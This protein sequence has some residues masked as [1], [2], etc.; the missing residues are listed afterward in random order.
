MKLNDK[1]FVAG[2]RGMVGS[3]IVRRLQQ[4]GYE[5]IVV[6]NHDKL[7]LTNQLWVN[8]FFKDEKP[9]YVFLAAARVGGI[10]ANDTYRAEFI[11]DN[12]MIEANVIH[13]AY[14]HGVK[15]LLA[16]GSSCIYP[17][18]SKR[19]LIE[20]DL[21]T[22]PLEPTNEPYAIAKVAGIKLC[23]AYRDQYGC[24]FISAMPCNIY[25]QG[26]NYGTNNTHV[27]PS[28]L[29]RFHEAKENNIP[30]VKVWGTGEPWREFVYS[31]D[32]ADACV[33][34]MNRYNGRLFLNIGTGVDIKIRDLAEKIKDVVGYGGHIEFDANMPDG[35]YRKVLNIEKLNSIGWKHTVSLDE[36]LQ[37]AYKYFKQELNGNNR[38]SN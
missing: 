9:D 36:G 21:M 12:L 23:E 15:K 37:M 26:D 6:R 31:D 4:D 22:G 1:I 28:L 24:N 20:E 38:E 25:G 11:Y 32:V 2:H 33:F 8:H 5:N 35:T 30:Y 34:M 7:D 16:L 14:V 13:A 17:R 3:A 29:R 27:L 18:E 19:P 10:L